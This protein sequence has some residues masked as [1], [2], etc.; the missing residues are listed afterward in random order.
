MSNPFENL[1]LKTA[2]YKELGVAM[3]IIAIATFPYL[4]DVLPLSE[5]PFHGFSTMRV[6]GYMLL[7]NLFAHFGWLTAFFIAK[8]KSYRFAFLVPVCLSAYQ[9]FIILFD[10]RD[11]ELNTINTKFILFITLSLFVV[12]N[13]FRTHR[14]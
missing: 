14:K 9:I 3:V 13:Y 8:G 12:I 4:H 5:E 10:L 1:K 6:F 2:T 7:M 11:S